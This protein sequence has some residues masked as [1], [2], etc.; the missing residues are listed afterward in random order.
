[1]T[2]EATRPPDAGTSPPGH[3]APPAE[4]SDHMTDPTEAH[5]Q[6]EDPQPDDPQQA[7]PAARHPLLDERRLRLLERF[8]EK[9]LLP[10]AAET[11]LMRSPTMPADDADSYY[12]VVDRAP[13]T[14]ADFEI[15]FSDPEEIAETLDQHWHGTPLEGLGR[16]LLKLSRHFE[17]VQEK[18]E[19]SSFVYE[20]F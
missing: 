11:G 13:L 7:A 10:L 5:G 20:M 4:G 14:P 6:P 3:S 12:E 15:P 8:F 17:D 9:H 2:A 18:A 16:Q 1:M 19:V